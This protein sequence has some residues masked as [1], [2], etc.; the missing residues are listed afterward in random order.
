MRCFTESMSTFSQT[1][2]SVSQTVTNVGF[3][4][5]NQPVNNHRKIGELRHFTPL[6]WALKVVPAG[7]SECNRYTA[8]KQHA[9]VHLSFQGFQ[10]LSYWRETGLCLLS[11]PCPPWGK[12]NTKVLVLL[13]QASSMTLLL[14]IASVL[15]AAVW[16]VY[17][18]FLCPLSHL[19]RFHLA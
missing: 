7:S 2:F 5:T 9:V 8:M 1:K 10:S 19:N 14:N 17:Y 11:A 12:E 13:F 15:L 18:V 16:L 3:H 6:K 4:L